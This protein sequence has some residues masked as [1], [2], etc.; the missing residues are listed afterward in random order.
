MSDTPSLSDVLE[1]AVEGRLARARTGLPG[2][3]QAYDATTRRATVQVLVTDG[4]IGEDGERRARELPAIPDVPVAAIGS[5]G[6]R[7]KFPIRVGDPCWLMFS[8]S[9]IARLKATG[10]LGDPGDDRHHHIADAV[11]L[12][13]VFGFGDA[14]QDGDG[15]GDEDAMIEF[16]TSGLI[17]AGGDEPLVT[18]SELLNHT[19]ASFGAPPTEIAPSGPTPFP[20]TGKLRG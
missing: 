8:S 14:P 16:T 9:S 1:A 10:R 17:R 6:I 15:D 20:G 4:V 13:L 5:R 7:I 18:R 19:H 11:A 3:I 12:P 2:R